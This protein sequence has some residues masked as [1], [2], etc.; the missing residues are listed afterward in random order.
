MNWVCT[1]VELAVFGPVIGDRLELLLV[2]RLFVERAVVSCWRAWK[3]ATVVEVVL[4]CWS[5][6]DR[7]YK[8]VP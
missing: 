1:G 6:N 2:P 7:K 5:W 3:L 4:H 8:K